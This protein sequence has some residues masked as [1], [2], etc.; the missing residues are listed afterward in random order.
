MNRS[1]LFGSLLVVGCAAAPPPPAVAQTT[2]STSTMTSTS[3][4]TSTPFVECDL[5][6]ERAKVISA[7]PDYHAQATANVNRVLEAMHPQ[8]LACYT[9]RVTAS[10]NAHGFIVVDILVAPDGTVRDVGATGGA[11]LGQRT[12]DCLVEQVRKAKFD[13]P[14][15][16]GTMRVE[17]PFSL[18]SAS[19]ADAQ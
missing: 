12:M 17:V 4:S 9:K 18:H 5:V 14:H 6:C 3:T 19:L 11:L 10:P 8:L 16:G 15:G 1:I 13:P 2:S 7:Q